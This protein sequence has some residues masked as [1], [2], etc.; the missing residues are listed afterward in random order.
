MIDLKLGIQLANGSES[1]AI[2]FLNMLVNS[3]PE[4]LAKLSTACKAKDLETTKSII[5]K[6]RGALSYWG[7]PRLREAC[8]KFDN[9]LASGKDEKITEQLYQQF[10]LEFSSLQEQ[11]ENLK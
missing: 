7:A 5:H 1:L 4:E 8:A 3:F 9:Y 6:L 2:E 11:I 10:L